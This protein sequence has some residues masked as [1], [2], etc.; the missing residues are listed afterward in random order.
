MNLYMNVYIFNK[1]FDISFFLLM[2]KLSSSIVFVCKE[3]NTNVPSKK[4]F[5]L[6]LNFLPGA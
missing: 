5:L 1:V 2:E 3:N 6:S 4:E